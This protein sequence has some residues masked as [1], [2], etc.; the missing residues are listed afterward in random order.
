MAKEAK[1]KVVLSK[2]VGW[3]ILA[4]LVVLDAVLDVIFVGGRGLESNILFPVANLLGIRNPL[5]LTPV[6]L[7]IFY[8]A[9]KAGA[10]LAEKVDKVKYKAEELTLTTLVIVY[11]VFDLWLVLV[12]LFHFSLFKSHYHLIPVLV[13][14][15]IGYSWWAERK[16]RKCW[17]GIS[18]VFII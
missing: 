5:F 9:V 4:L 6:V 3:I 12:Y 1:D 16:L 2:Q 15:G 14:I 17:I 10:W 11:A 8:F 13:V 18:K 7:V